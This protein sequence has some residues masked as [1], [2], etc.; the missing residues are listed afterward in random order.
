[1][2]ELL[3]MRHGKSDWREACADFDRPLNP[4]GERDARAMG[5]W[6]ARQE[7][8]PPAILASPAR[9]ARQTAVAVAMALN[10]SPDDIDYRDALYLAD[11]ETL[12]RLL[13]DRL[14]AGAQRLLLVGHNP[15]LD[16]L[17]TWLAAALPSRTA[18]GKLMTTA[19]IAAFSVP[20][21]RLLR[22]ASGRLRFLVRP[23]ALR[24]AGWPDLS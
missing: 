17:V 21:G 16:E 7:R 3:L 1:M 13:G 18:S 19:A 24:E 20:D 10:R 11:R 8:L 4:R 22:P 5:E 14:R 15:G 6:L 9:R 2:A 12:V 23:K